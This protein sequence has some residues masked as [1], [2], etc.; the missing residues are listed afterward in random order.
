MVGRKIVAESF[1]AAHP[2]KRWVHDR[3]VE[4]LTSETVVPAFSAVVT[5]LTTMTRDETV[6][7][8]DIA[9]LVALDQGLSTR[10]LRAANAPSRG[11]QAISNIQEA[12]FLIGLKEMRRIALTVGVMD[13]FNHLRIKINWRKFWLHSVLV[14]RLTDKLA[15]AF[16]EVNGMEYLAGLMHDIGKLILEHYFPREFEAIVLRS[17]ERRCG[18]AAA[19]F[20]LLGLDHTCIGAALCQTLH[21][22]PHIVHAV[23]FHHQPVHPAHTGNPEGDGGFLSACISVADFLANLREINIGGQKELAYKLEDLPEWN[24]LTEF[25]NCR[26]LALDLDEEIELAEL[27]I[28]S[29]T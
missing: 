17:M 3:I 14:A 28:S 6:G 21:V 11:G 29:I 4:L 10:C 7:L 20:D 18:H 26:G 19:E 15:G 27:E 23:Q 25:F 24:Y 22:H 2:A 8:E 12:L 1:L 9:D 13:N 5:K 16:R